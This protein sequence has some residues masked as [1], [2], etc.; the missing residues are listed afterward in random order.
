MAQHLIP[1]SDIDIGLIIGYDCPWAI[2]PTKLIPPIGDSPFAQKTILGWGIVRVI[3]NTELEQD[4]LGA[5]HQVMLSCDSNI[6]FWNQVKVMDFKSIIKLLARDIMHD[7]VTCLVHYQMPLPFNDV[8]L[9][10]NRTTSL[11]QLDLHFRQDST[12]HMRY[13]TVIGSMH[14]RHMLN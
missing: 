14:L 6:S 4:P 10:N 11:R 5:S 1:I 12:Y 9:L 2:Y 7:S 13:Q 8:N 3:D